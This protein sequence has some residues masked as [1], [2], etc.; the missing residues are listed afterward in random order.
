[1]AKSGARGT[2]LNIVWFN[3][4]LGQQAP[5]TSGRIHRGYSTRRVLPLMMPKDLRAEAH[6]FVFSNFFEGLSPVDI[7]MHAVGARGSVIHKGLLTAR[8]GYLYRRLSNALQDYYVF[9]DNSVRDTNSNMIQ[10]VYG[11]DAIDPTKVR[12][13]GAEKE[14]AG[15]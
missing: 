3:M 8:S 4:F 12:F 5:L 2:I 14:E 11:G 10:I 6:G 13:V 9:G 7:F 15:E 1:M